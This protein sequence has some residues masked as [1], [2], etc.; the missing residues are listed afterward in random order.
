MGIGVSSLE[1]DESSC[2]SCVEHMGQIL[3]G[4]LVHMFLSFNGARF[5]MARRNVP[6][7]T[8]SP[9]RCTKAQ[10]TRLRCSIIVRHPQ[11]PN[12]QMPITP[13]ESLPRSNLPPMNP[14]VSTFPTPPGFV[15]HPPV[16]SSAFLHH[17]KVGFMT[18][19][20]TFYYTASPMELSRDP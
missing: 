9:Q 14:T 18:H 10:D 19:K 20:S 4:K 11:S 12:E 17:R 15:Q 8:L 1:T 3:V 7:A 5:R 13:S 2:R 16:R 6:A